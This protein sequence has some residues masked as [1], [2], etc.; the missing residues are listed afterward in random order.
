MIARERQRAG[1]L[2]A[3][4]GDALAR[5]GIDEIEGE[6]LEDRAGERHRRHRFGAGVRAPERLQI[7]VVQG[8]HAERDAVHAGR[9]I[10]EKALRLDAGRI[11]FER[12]LGVL[13][14]SSNGARSRRE[15][16]RRLRPAS[17]RACRRRKTP[18]RP[19]RPGVSAARWLS[20][21][22]KA[23]TNRASSSARLPHM[24]VEI[25]IGAFRQAEGP[26][27]INAKAGIRAALW[28]ISHVILCHAR[29]RQ[30]LEKRL[31]ESGM[32]KSGVH[33]SSSPALHFWE[34]ITSYAFAV[35][36]TKRIVI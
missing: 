11:G 6:A 8:L 19:S 35:D 28:F 13:A 12:D 16:R 32:R 22:A 10:A 9:A 15:W 34:L 5:P 1:K 20:S 36:S 31:R 21:R 27:H 14:R 30:S 26:V 24:A 23:A 7:G 4:V 2:G 33:F 17:A 25:A 29:P 3:P 18:R